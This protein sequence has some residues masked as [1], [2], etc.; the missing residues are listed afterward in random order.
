MWSDHVLAALLLRKEPL[1][2]I[3]VGPT[4]GLDEID[5]IKNPIPLQELN[6]GS[7]VIQLTA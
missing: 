4:P 6:H 7:L 1:L 3:R 2:S 5:S